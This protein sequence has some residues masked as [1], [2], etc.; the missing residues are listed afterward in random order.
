MRRYGSWGRY[1]AATPA[2][3]VP[4]QWRSDT[5]AFA[6]LRGLLLPYAYGRSY[7]DS[8]LNDGGVI[9]DVRGLDRLIDFDADSGLLRCEA[10]VTLAEILALIV[11]RGW[12]LPVVPGTRWVSVGGA[13]AN[14]IHGKNHH[15]AGT[16][17]AHVTR[18][19]LLR[20]DGA[21]IL[22]TPGDEIFRATVG[23][24]GLTGVIL[25]AEIRLKRIPGAGISMERIRFSALAGFLE[26]T[27]EDHQ[28]EYTVAWVDCLARGRRLG[29][30]IYMR[31]DHAPLDATTPSPLEPPRLS[32]PLDAPAG[33]LNAV[34]LGLFN[35]A[36]YR[37]QLRVRRRLT[38]PYTP[39]FFPLDVVGDW[40]R[41]YGPKGFV[42]YQ[43]VVPDTPGGAPIRTIF[44]R[45]S[46]SGEPAS[47]AVLKRFG[48]LRSP[49]LL[50]FPREGMTLAVDFPFRGPATMT[51]LDDLDAVVRETG[52]AVYPAKDARM[53]PGSFQA[54]FP[55]LDRFTAQRDPKFSS[56]FW[57]R[58]HAS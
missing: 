53:S 29:R 14:D 12:F 26:L 5:P 32:I 28:F 36:Y 9:L 55:E 27:A 1:P 21:R 24:L 8:C 2:T 11:P 41:L 20:S 43:C 15:R 46:R 45:I 10:G 38:L 47:L 33:L 34:T 56:S 51:L 7:G 57:R 42:Q 44:E 22:C 18:L 17:G 37:A 39:F 50:S 23:G 16:F 52:G 54:F 58:V 4:L 19:E 13:I 49:G 40:G 3:V 35:E 48:G 25:W 31:G 30:G 6:Q